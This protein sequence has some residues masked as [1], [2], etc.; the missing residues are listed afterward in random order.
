MPGWDNAV[1]RLKKMNH[2]RQ[3]YELAS[4]V[5]EAF[6]TGQI[7]ECTPEIRELLVR[8][9]SDENMRVRKV[10]ANDLS[11]LGEDVFDDIAIGLCNDTNTFVK[12]A[13]QRSFSLRR[14]HK[15]DQTKQESDH[16]RLS[17][18]FGK[19]RE[20]YGEDAI[21]EI[22][23]ISEARYNILAGSMA[24]DMRSILTHLKPSAKAIIGSNGNPKAARL[25]AGLELIESCVAD[26]ESYT[27]PLPVERNPQDL[28]EILKSACDMGRKNIEELGYNSDT[29]TLKLDVQDGLR[30]RISR[31]LIIFAVANLVKNAY[32]SFMDGRK[33]R[34]GEIS[35]QAGVVG[36]IEKGARWSIEMGTT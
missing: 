3:R 21:G 32:E 17:K 8:L 36:K 9:A 7:L 24:H 11:L 20:K 19:I 26:M 12:Q 22:L 13:A 29:V 5:M 4:E 27:K 30:L 35:V 6:Q 18:M 25:V 16:K 33:L 1:E 34:P 15:Q 31:H 14:K 10:I 23:T 28:C 2:W